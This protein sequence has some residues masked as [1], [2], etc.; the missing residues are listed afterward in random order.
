MDVFPYF[1]WE[2]QYLASECQNKPLTLYR[3]QIVLLNMKADLH[4]FL[5]FR[6]NI[7]FDTDKSLVLAFGW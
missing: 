1:N 6:S 7:D 2:S 3:I 5:I 4:A